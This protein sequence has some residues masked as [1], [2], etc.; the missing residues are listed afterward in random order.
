[1]FLTGASGYVGGAVARAL[2]ARGVAVAALVRSHAAAERLPPGAEPVPGDLRDP[3][4]WLAAARACDAAVH[5]AFEYDAAGREA[6][7]ADATA[8]D[9]LLAEAGAGGPLRHVVYTSNA[10]L[11]GDHPAGTVDESTPIE[12]ARLARTPRLATEARVLARG[13][14]GAAVRVGAVYG[15]GA[16]GTIPHV[17]AALAGGGAL[18]ALEHRPTRWSLVHLDDLAQLYVQV[19]D[20]GARGVFH[21]TDGAPMPVADVVRH[22]RAALAQ[23]GPATVPPGPAA[24]AADA[25]ASVFGGEHLGRLGADVAVLPVASRALGWTPRVP[26]FAAGAPE[27]ARAWRALASAAAER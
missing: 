27:A 1:V 17:F 7:D 10:F 26:S 22:A 24:A 12:P 25:P 23:L 9:A 2:L 13:D 16:G 18:P 21:G 3:A 20:R 6:P 5:A 4:A 8:V 19:L 14:V 11:L 15:T